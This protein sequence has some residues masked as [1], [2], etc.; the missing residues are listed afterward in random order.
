MFVSVAKVEEIPPGS[1]KHV[2][3]GDV[4]LAVARVGDDFYATQGHCA[5]LQGPLGHSKLDEHLLRCPWHGWTYD[6]RT[7]LNDFDLAIQ[8]QTF[9]V[10]VEDGEVQ[11]AV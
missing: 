7:G 4:E 6:L 1:V 11:V 2:R 10:R 8:L 5:H 9:E 3:A